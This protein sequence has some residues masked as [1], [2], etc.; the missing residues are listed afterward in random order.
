M[1]DRLDIFEN[2]DYI[3]KRYPVIYIVD[4]S[5]LMA[6][7]GALDMV[8]NALLSI[9]AAVKAAA[10]EHHAEEP[11]FSAISVSDTAKWI[12][13]GFVSADDFYWEKLG[14]GGDLRFSEAFEALCD[15]TADEPFLL[16]RGFVRQPLILFL[17]TGNGMETEEEFN[18]A[19]AQLKKKR[20]FEVATKIAIAFGPD[21]NIKRLSAAA[22]DPSA[23]ISV[24]DPEKLKEII[25]YFSVT[26]WV[27]GTVS[28]L[29][30]LRTAS[31]EM[32]DSAMKSVFGDEWNTPGNFSLPTN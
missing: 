5:A 29:D 13:N 20:W 26:G 24:S 30:G 22:S 6:D 21:P 2:A 28:R 31:L 15:G 7:C 12:F 18:N 17:S 32:I 9:P 14:S 23:V 4:N 8:N 10:A 1:N 27:T 19:L 25:K 3:K 11:L 16:H